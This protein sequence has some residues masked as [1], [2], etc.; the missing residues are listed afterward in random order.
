MRILICAAL[1]LVAACGKA[2]A[3]K[4]AYGHEETIH[5][6]VDISL[7]D[8]EGKQL[9]LGYKTRIQYFGAGLYLNDEGYVLGV[10]G[11]YSSYYAM[12]TGETL[13]RF[14]TDGLLPN[15]LPPYSVSVWSYLL[16]YS[17]WWILAIVLSFYAVET[18]RESKRQ[19]EQVG[20]DLSLAKG[21][22]SSDG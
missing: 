18:Y 11:E 3:G 8:K 22:P 19:K 6:I 1:V 15:P 21:R 17:T 4:F 13:T 2:T 10:E 20:T 9:F 14:Q 7:K 16:G 12:P 5:K